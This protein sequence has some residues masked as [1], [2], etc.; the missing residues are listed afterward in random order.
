[1][2]HLALAALIVSLV[3]LAA[4]ALR[5]Q[6]LVS[7]RRPESGQF[8]EQPAGAGASGEHLGLRPPLPG[9]PAAGP[10]RAE[11][12]WGR[13]AELASSPYAQESVRSSGGLGGEQRVRRPARDWP[14]RGQPPEFSVSDTAVTV[15]NWTIPIALSAGV[16]PC[17]VTALTDPYV[18]G[19]EVFVRSLLYASP[20]FVHTRWPLVVIDQGL[21]NYSRQRLHALYAHTRIEAAATG[22]VPHGANLN[23][24]DA[25]SGKW[26]ANLEKIFQVFHMPACAP[27][28]K[29]DSGDMLVL[30]DIAELLHTAV[31]RSD[32]YL[33]AAA[34]VNAQ[35]NN[36]GL[37]VLGRERLQSPQ[38][39]KD[40]RSLA[41]AS[42]PYREQELLKDY[43]KGA[44]RPH[45]VRLP[46][47]FNVEYKFWSKQF[48]GTDGRPRPSE[49]VL[50][51][52]VGYKPWEYSRPPSGWHTLWWQYHSRGRLLVIGSPR[53]AIAERSF[54]G[55]V[56]DAFELVARIDLLDAR[57]PPPG[58]ST[59]SAC[60]ARAR[61]VGSAGTR[62]T[63]V[64]LA[65][66]SQGGTRRRG[67]AR[68]SRA[69][70]G[71]TAARSRACSRSGS[72][73]RSARR[74]AR[75][76]SSTRR[77]GPRAASPPRST[78]SF[79]P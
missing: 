55:W 66:R 50:M 15:G 39:L 59:S 12:E 63:A 27:I 73:R 10:Q 17:F 16:S 34:L 45:L 35:L 77:C 40:L 3:I 30:D 71:R 69:A 5:Y 44:G 48:G 61:A 24:G 64:V 2:R 47:K 62:V 26:K 46:K 70:S 19:H 23:K 65:R 22:L 38:T 41:E 37:L 36:M 52:F 9:R 60:L 56:A 75:S 31:Q 43:F 79:A 25:M 51:H 32:I 54:S 57:A 76:G 78:S 42:H 1:M 18:D 49:V 74:S 4:L 72:P 13:A 58:H 33:A 28:V 20:W 14:S 11:P 8:A 68:S 53:L 6:T 21:S 29:L 67:R 7:E